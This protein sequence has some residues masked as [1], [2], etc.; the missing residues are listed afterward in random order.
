MFHLFFTSSTTIQPG[1]SDEQRNIPS[2][3]HFSIS[4]SV[5]GRI[6]LLNLNCLL[7]QLF[8]VSMKSFTLQCLEMQ[9]KVIPLETLEISVEALLQIS[10][11]II[12]CYRHVH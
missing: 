6:N 11:V 12:N 9:N 7:T 8:H 2:L 5:V 1:Y 10:R 3:I 4:I